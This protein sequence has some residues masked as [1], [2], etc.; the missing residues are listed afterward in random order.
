MKKILIAIPTAR[1]I[2][3]DTFKS[4][5]DLILPE[6]YH[7]TYQHFYGYRVDQVR[8]LIAD[9][10]VKGFDYLF[11]VDHDIVLPPDALL[12][13]L[14]VDKPLVCGVYRQ[15]VEPQQIE[16]F[17][18]PVQTRMSIEELYSAPQ[19]RV[20]IGGCGFGCTLVH[21]DVLIKVGY[22][23]FEYHVALDHANTISE[24]TDFCRKVDSCGIEMWCDRTVLCGHIGSSTLHVQVPVNNNLERFKE[25]RSQRLLP[26]KHIDYLKRLSKDITPKV[27]YDIGSCVLHWTDEARSIW[28]DANIIPFEAMSEVSAL[29]DDVG[30]E[31]YVTGCLI[32]NR[33]Q[34]QVKFYQNL[35]H[36]GGNSKYRENEVYSPAASEYFPE[37]NAKNKPMYTLDT[38]FEK[39]NL[40]LPDLIKMDIQGS[41]MDA[42]IGA[43][44]VLETCN[45]VILEL[46]HV[47]YNTGA[48]GYDEVVDFMKLKGFECVACFNGDKDNT[49]DGDYH[50][51][52]RV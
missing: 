49:V 31:T 30:I 33:D 9:W 51:T 38:L 10:V 46:Q 45:D 28:P 5:Y 23:Q 41:E 39:L 16:I 2:E 47:A 15:R 18:Y 27:I 19:D 25:L 43:S 3:A 22:P 13:L 44:K 36:P 26:V 40:P 8:N 7:V 29:Y 24:D 17:K 11:S 20:R 6:G 21:K 32:G 34:E 48:P 42:L 52:R 35:Y 37:S 50:F 4:I 14:R 12:K 1:Y